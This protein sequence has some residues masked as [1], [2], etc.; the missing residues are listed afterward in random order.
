MKIVLYHIIP[1]LNTKHLLFNSLDYINKSCGDKFPADIY[2]TVFS[3]GIKAKNCEDVFRIFTY[4]LTADHLQ[5][6]FKK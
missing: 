4:M 2:E 5:I 1:E 6:S 3:G